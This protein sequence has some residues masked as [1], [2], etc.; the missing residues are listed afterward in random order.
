MR[1]PRALAEGDRIAIVAPASPFDRDEFE[2]GVAEL[3]RLGFEPVYDESVFA[4]RSYVAGSPEVRAAAFQ[5][6]WDD[7]AIAGVIAVRGGYGSAQILPLLD[8]HAVRLSAK[9]FV[10]YSDLTAMLTFLTLNCGIVAFH[11]PML[12]KRFARGAAGYD[13]ESFRRAVCRAEPVGE[14]TTPAVEALR[15]GEAAGVLLGGT[16]TQLLA[17]LG[18]PYA[19]APPPGYVLFIEEVGERPYRLDR[20]VTQLKH[21]GLLRQASAVVIGEL[22]QCDEPSGDVTARAVMADLFADFPGPV[23]VGLPS[24]HTS[25]PA[26]T[27]PFGVAARVVADRRPRLVI[28]ESAVA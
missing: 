18:T 12:E 10:G 23:L 13:R 28:E 14:I 11:G 1:K 6:A 7:P 4:R 19:F 24:G 16:L 3:R 5:A 21:T 8:P 20:M 25:G 26:L 22:V 9:C 2:R 17:S 15:S 27:L